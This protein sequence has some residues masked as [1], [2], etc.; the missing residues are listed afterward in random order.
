MKNLP[1]ILVAMLVLAGGITIWTQDRQ[2]QGL[3][4]TVGS[5]GDR[6]T[7]QHRVD[8]LTKQLKAAQDQ[9]ATARALATKKAAG[10]P[11]QT[12]D[13]KGAPLN[14]AGLLNN[15]AMQKMMAFSIRASFDS[16][17]GPLFKSLHL[18]AAQVDQL[19]DLMVQRQQA[20]QDATL[21]AAQ[22]GM[23]MRNDPQGLQQAVTAAQDSVDEQIKTELG[24]AG[25]A[26]YQ[27]FEQTLPQ[28]NMAN[29][30]QM[31]LSYT[32]TPLSDDQASQLT[33]LLVQNAQGASP[34]L[35]TDQAIAAAQAILSPPQLQALQQLQRQQQ[36]QAQ[37]QQQ[38]LEA[39][40]ASRGGNVTVPT[41]PGGG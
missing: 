27:Q 10:N 29:R 19:K 4:D 37:F 12:A 20:R 21:A 36:A 28:R 24:E 9:L 32:A 17:H 39:A 5:A 11:G 23:T 1:I 18:S 40:R 2:I 30:V 16:T 34:N 15:E 6:A 41:S 25:F 35:V 13:A 38:I 26:Q 7:L 33:Q 14:I 8:D 22:Q 3:R 31:S